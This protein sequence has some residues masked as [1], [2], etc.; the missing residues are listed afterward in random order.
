MSLINEE[1]KIISCTSRHNEA[2]FYDT[3]G[4]MGRTGVVVEATIQ[5]RSIETSFIK[6]EYQKIS[7]LGEMMNDFDYSIN[8]T[9]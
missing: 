9:Y 8:W 5:L 1:G 3:V 7:N 6:Y 4:G 2:L